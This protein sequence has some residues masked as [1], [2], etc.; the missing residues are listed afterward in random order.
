MIVKGP[1]NSYCHCTITE[2]QIVL[3]FNW[4]NTLTRFVLANG[5]FLVELA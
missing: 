2:T 1:E 3:F 4:K 5:V